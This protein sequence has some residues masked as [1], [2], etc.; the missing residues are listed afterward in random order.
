[1]KIAIIGIGHVGTAVAAKFAEVGHDV[2]GIDIDSRKVESINN[3]MNP[4]FGSE[5]RLPELLASVVKSGKL[6]ATNDYSVCKTMDVIIL[7]VETPFDT[8]RKR[9]LYFALRSALESLSPF[10]QKGTLVIVESTL[11][12]TTSNTL[13]IPLLEAGSNLKAGIDFNYSHAPERVM[14]GRLLKNIET[15]DRVVG[16][17]TPEC[18]NRTKELYQQITSGT[19][20]TTTNIMAEMVKTTENAYRDVQIA[21]AN[22]IALLAH[23]LDLDVFQLREYV[24]KV[25]GRNMLL[26]G[27]GVGG[28]CIPKDS[29][30]L[31]YGTRGKYQPRI[32][33][34]A[35]DIND[36]MP[37][38]V[39][40]LCEESLS[41]VDKKL[42]KSKVTVLGV[43]FLENSGDIRNS[44]ATTILEDLEVFNSKI[45]LHDPYV[46]EFNGFKVEKDVYSAVKESDV[47]I[48]VTKHDEYFKIDF[49]KVKSLMNDSPIL[50]D[51]RN[52]YKRD[53]LEAKGFIYQGVGK[54]KHNDKSE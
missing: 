41:L 24:N 33:S 51:G 48:L 1:M 49:D 30:L 45:V 3:G 25:P 2:T 21:F 15:L 46:T 52:V 8:R 26:P 10:V 31:A 37:H 29:W 19:V 13:I 14:P 34:D 16:G 38:Y 42:N 22:E 4:L 53:D 18:A 23:S 40:D 27:A 7:A 11:A 47:I 17:V 36:Y 12:P 39:T 50:I 32:L 20:D 43:S 54:Y 44:P 35:R 5:P 6:K 9:P 28:H